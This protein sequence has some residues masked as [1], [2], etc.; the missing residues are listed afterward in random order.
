MLI[1]QRLMEHFASGCVSLLPTRASHAVRIVVS[2]A[3]AAIADAVM[4]KQA[5][6]CVSAVSAQLVV[7]FI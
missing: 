2:A 6:D 7:R 3:I 1:L 4:R 5:T